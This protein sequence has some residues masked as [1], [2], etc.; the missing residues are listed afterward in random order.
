MSS[1]ASRRKGLIAVRVSS[2]KQG[3]DG[4]SP[5]AQREQGERYAS[6]NNIRVVKTLAYLESASK[7]VQPM[8]DVIDYCKSHRGEVDVVIIKSIDRLTRGGSYFYDNLKRQLGPLGV[9]LLDIYGVISNTKVNTLDHLGFKYRW[10]EYS[11]S[12]KTELLEAE[13]ANDELRDILSRMIGSEIRYTQLGYWARESPYGF[14]I[15]KMDTPNGKRAVLKKHP[16]EGVIIRKLFELRAEGTMTDDQIADELNRMGFRTRVKL[17]RSKQN[18]TEVIGQRGGKPMTGKLLRSYIEKTI[19]AGINT[20]KWTGG[21]PVRCKFGEIVSI[22]LFNKANRG[23]IAITLEPNDPDHPIVGEAPKNEM[24]AKKSV[25]N[26]DFPYRRVVTCPECKH[27]L[28]G[29]ASKGRLGKYYPAYHCTNHGHYFRVPKPEFDAVIEGFINS[30]IISPERVSEL[31]EAVM[32]VWQKRQQQIKQD[33][34]F[35]DKRRAELETQIRLIVDKMKMVSSATAIKYMEEDLVKI[36][37]QITDLD[38]KESPKGDKTADMGVVLTYIKYFMEHL[39]ELLVDTCNPLAKADYFGV[40]FDK[41]ISYDEIKDG[42]QNASQITGINEL[43]RLTYLEKDLLVRG[44]G[45][46]PPSLAALAPHASVYTIPPPARGANQDILA[47][48]R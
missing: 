37:Q 36:E 45:L 1:E 44:R 2:A 19:Y 46:E 38:G 26:P 13:R 31:M 23:K 43:F 28:L 25:A 27:P 22:E 3:I 15:E 30:L 14:K 18:K 47:Q 10:S 42:T 9:E 33:A 17:L 48:I 41:V 5:E 24:R 16:D 21:K 4:D 29:S 34:D 6:V 7:E 39:R 35:S 20:E 8:Q 32:T 11:P 40:L 12:R